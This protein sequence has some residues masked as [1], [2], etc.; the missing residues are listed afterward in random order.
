MTS[1]SNFPGKGTFK[2]T[3]ITMPRF[4]QETREWLY[5]RSL[6][7]PRTS[8]GTPYPCSQDDLERCLSLQAPNLNPYIEP[9]E[10]TYQLVR[11]NRLTKPLSIKEDNA[12]NRLEG[13]LTHVSNPGDWEP[14]IA[15]KAFKDLD[16]L[17][18]MSRLRGN[19][20]VRWMDAEHRLA[21]DGCFGSTDYLAHGQA[22]IHLNA[23]RI[24]LD[25]PEPFIEMWRV[26]EKSFHCLF[27][28]S[29]L[30][31]LSSDM[32][33]GRRV[34]TELYKAVILLGLCFE[35]GTSHR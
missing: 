1:Q 4:D 19:C 6:R 10:A 26:S 29:W 33:H 31:S 16:T 22:Q 14:S 8:K 34:S 15:I 5:Q 20:K 13:M 2:A 27:F 11:F 17:F 25:C 3:S 7:K 32:S 12:L 24:L 21:R 30:P 23:K 9:M 28:L 18:F 35:S